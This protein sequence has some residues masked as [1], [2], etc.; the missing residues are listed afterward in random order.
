[1][2]LKTGLANK[3]MAVPEYESLPDHQRINNAFLVGSLIWHMENLLENAKCNTNIVKFQRKAELTDDSMVVYFPILSKTRYLRLQLKSHVPFSYFDQQLADAILMAHSISM[4]KIIDIEYDGLAYHFFEF[5]E[6]LI[7]SIYVSLIASDSWNRELSEKTISGIFDFL[8]AL[9]GK[10]YEGSPVE[11]SLSLLPKRFR[12]KTP[13]KPVNLSELLNSKKTLSLFRGNRHLLEC[14]IEG[15]VYNLRTLK[16]YPDN[17]LLKYAPIHVAPYEYQPTFNYSRKERALVF[18][19]NRHGDI[20][21]SLEGGLILSR[22]EN[23]W[24]IINPESFI[25]SI[26]SAVSEFHEESKGESLID[27]FSIY[28][29]MLSFSLRNQ[30]RGGLLVVAERNDIAKMISEKVSEK[31]SPEFFYQSNFS[32]R[33]L[34]DLSVSM[35]CN[36]IAL[37]GATLIDPNGVILGFGAILNTGQRQSKSEGART[38]AAEYASRFG[39]ALKVS[40]D[41]PISLYKRSKLIYQIL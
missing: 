40:E 22:N 25:A 33:V 3:L 5:L 29:G 26:T 41:G 30:R 12:K 17:G 16:P 39:L 28:L 6:H 32:G 15:K 11:V 4:D 1:M 14:D 7:I 31:D 37:D 2:Q 9:S 23:V 36:L 19:L 18:I 34:P 27:A 38:R 8:R 21:V 20:L 24:K 10:H 35:F 13:A